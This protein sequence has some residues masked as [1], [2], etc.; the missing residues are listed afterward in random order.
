MENEGF[1]GWTNRATWNVSHWLNNDEHLYSL[2]Q[3]LKLVD[4]AQF[5]NLC[6]Y[7]WKETTP[8]GDELD[9][10]DW[11]EIAESWRIQK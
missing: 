6:R 11:Q 10:V 5:E 8:D 3:S 9:N 7:V 2:A 1:K 4:A